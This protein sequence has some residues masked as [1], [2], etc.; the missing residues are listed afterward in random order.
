MTY[1]TKTDGTRRSAKEFLRVPLL[2]QWS[3]IIA[4]AA[5]PPAH[6]RLG[7]WGHCG[8]PNDED[9]STPRRQV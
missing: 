2:R 8:L 6:G 4:P 3:T 5:S 9:D 1:R 7:L